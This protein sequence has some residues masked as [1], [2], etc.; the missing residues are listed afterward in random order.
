MSIDED[1]QT[2]RDGQNLKLIGFVDM[3]DEASCLSTIKNK[4][5]EKQLANHMLL[6]QF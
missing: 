4:S 6:M 1:L 2:V 5:D 3:G